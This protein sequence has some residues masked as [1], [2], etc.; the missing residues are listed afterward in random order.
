MEVEIYLKNNILEEVNKIR[1]LGI[2]FDSKI[3][4]REHISYMKEKCVILIF[5]LSRSGKVT[6][7]LRHETLETI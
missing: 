5:A 1:Y 4:F 2:I 7:G 6:W 3:L